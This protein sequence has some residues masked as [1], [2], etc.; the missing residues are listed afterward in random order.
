MEHLRTDMIQ[1]HH[2]VFSS[3]LCVAELQAHVKGYGLQKV[4]FMALIYLWLI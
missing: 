2:Y 3:P 4:T 1:I